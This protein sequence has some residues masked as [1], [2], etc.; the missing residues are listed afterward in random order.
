MTFFNGFHWPTF[1]YSLIFFIVV[2]NIWKIVKATITL[3]RAKKKVKQADAALKEMLQ[4]LRSKNQE[5]EG[6]LDKFKRKKS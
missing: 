2:A 1:F 6:L 3:N 4:A 5:I